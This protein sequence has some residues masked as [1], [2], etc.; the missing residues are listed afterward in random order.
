[1]KLP[2][3]PVRVE[4]RRYLSDADPLGTVLA[5][6]RCPALDLAQSVGSALRGRS[7]IVSG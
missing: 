3:A 4:R 2:L 6:E 7:G 1:M 5:R